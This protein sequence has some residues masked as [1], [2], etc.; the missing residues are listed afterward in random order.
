MNCIAILAVLVFSTSLLCA[1]D[2]KPYD[3]LG[4]EN[5]RITAKVIVAGTSIDRQWGSDSGSYE[6]NRTSSLEVEVV[7]SPIGAKA[8]PLALH[9]YFVIRD[10]SSGK[11]VPSQ[12][13]V[14]ALAV[15]SGTARFSGDASRY[16]TRYGGSGGKKNTSGNAFAGWFVRAVRDRKIVGIAGSAAKYEEMAAKP[17]PET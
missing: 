9:F 13:D 1:Q 7:V 12:C 8:E 16:E 10:H 15:G 5:V 6:R 4:K 2:I 17:T 11:E 3:R 14:Q